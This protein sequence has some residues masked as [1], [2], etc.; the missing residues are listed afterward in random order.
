MGDDNHE[1]HGHPAACECHKSELGAQQLSE[2][3]FDRSLPGTAAN[4][5]IGKLRR[6][7]QD[8]KDVNATDRDGYTALVR[9][10]S[11]L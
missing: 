4:G 10:L 1:H 2:V 11:S 7:M 6:M 5:D 3:Q 8:G 9:Q